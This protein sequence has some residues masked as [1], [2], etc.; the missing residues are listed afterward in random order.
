[1]VLPTFLG[2][3]GHI[4]KGLEGEEENLEKVS[5]CSVNLIIWF[6]DVQSYSSGNDETR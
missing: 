2:I 3:M 6:E 1:M 5:D 4:I